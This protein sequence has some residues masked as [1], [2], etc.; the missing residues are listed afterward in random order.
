MMLSTS[1]IDGIKLYS[2]TPVMFGNWA[3][4]SSITDNEVICLILFN[5]LTYESN[6]KYFTDE[7]LAHDYLHYSLI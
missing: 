4:K 7:E 5:T 6:V 1:T 3:V 2:L